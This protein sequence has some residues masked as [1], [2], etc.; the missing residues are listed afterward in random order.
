MGWRLV[1]GGAGLA[2]LGVLATLWAAPQIPVLWSEGF[3]APVWDGKAQVV[4]VDGQSS[5][6]PPAAPPS[7]A[8]HQRFEGSGGRALLAMRGTQ[9]IAEAYGPGITRDTQLNSYSLVKTLVGVL[10]LKAVAEGHI[11]DLDTPLP[12]LLGDTAPPV[13]LD[14]V[15][16][17]TAGLS[18]GHEPPK[19]EKDASFDDDTF[20]PFSPVARLHAFGIERL[21]PRIRTNPSLR[22]Q[23]HYQSVNTALLGLVAER[24]YGMPLPDLLAREIWQ[25]AGAAPASWRRNP[26]SGRATAYCCLYARAQDWLHVGRFLLTNG[27]ETAPL[28]APDLWQRWI[29]PQLDAGQRRKGV[30]GWHLRH[31]VLDRPGASLQGPFA[32]LAGHG[33]QVV[34]LLPEQDITV[35]RFGAEPQLLHSTLYDLFP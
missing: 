35:V 17:M 26:A 14:E 23:F 25:P 28:L 30:Y 33:G 2:V 34:Y 1:L 29:L 4:E 20:S 8:A 5:P 19:D 11:A 18:L 12:E 15:L 31:D 27:T 22:G 32:Y 21:L 9:V 3:P 16:S 10:V 7:G 24:A 13:R 6:L